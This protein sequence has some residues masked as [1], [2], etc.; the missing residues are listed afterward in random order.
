MT[1]QRRRKTQVR[2]TQQATGLRYTAAARALD[3]AALRPG[4]FRMR[5][6][7]RECATRPA[8]ELD[9]MFRDPEDGWS[10]QVFVSTLLGTA[11]PFAS[12]MSLAGVLATDG[13]VEEATVETVLAVETVRE[14]HA[15]VVVCAGKRYRL[16]IGDEGA[17]RLCGHAPCD[18]PPALDEIAPRCSRHLDTATPRELED[19]AR[20]FGY[21]LADRHDRDTAAK[22]DL[23]AAGWLAEAAAAHGT[24]DLVVDT[25]LRACFDDPDNLDDTDQYWDRNEADAIR[26]A[27]NRERRR[28]LGIARDTTDRIRREAKTCAAC[29]ASLAA[30]GVAA[31]VPPQYCSAACAPRPATVRDPWGSPPF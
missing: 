26:Q 8:G 9:W 2:E 22:T 13:R 3:E 25:F 18:H 23:P 14:G 19:A 24:A 20:D 5:E 10:P 28:L 17:T 12:V 29:A 30:A 4:T 15:A 21:H 11:V 1:R 6:L 16:G 31:W 27:M 7:L